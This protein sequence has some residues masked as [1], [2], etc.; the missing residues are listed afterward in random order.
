MFI[1]DDV[2]TIIVSA[3][4]TTSTFLTISSNFLFKPIFHLA[5]ST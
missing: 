5:V 2:S 3:F 1:F 4:F